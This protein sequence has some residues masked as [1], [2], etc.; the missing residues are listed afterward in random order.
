MSEII[1]ALILERQQAREADYA[2][3]Q[4]SRAEFSAEVKRRRM[5]GLRKRHA[6]KLGRVKPTERL[7]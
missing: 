2:E 7:V 1:A 3:R 5:Y 6:I 4:A